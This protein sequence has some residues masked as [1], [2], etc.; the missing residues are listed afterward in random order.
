MTER[1]EAASERLAVSTVKSEVLT[2]ELSM[3]DRELGLQPVPLAYT[4]QVGLPVCSVQYS[5]T[6][7][8]Y[9]N[10]AQHKVLSSAHAVIW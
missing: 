8:Y 10:W 2:H 3:G 5:S 1:N 9:W 6:A 7:T 4:Q